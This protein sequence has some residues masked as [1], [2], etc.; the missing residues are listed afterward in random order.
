VRLKSRK[1]VKQTGRTKNNLL[2][3]RPLTGIIHHPEGNFFEINLIISPFDL[4]C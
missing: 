1:R 2:F 3:I 4:N